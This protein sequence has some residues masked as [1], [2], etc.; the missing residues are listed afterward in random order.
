MQILKE[1]Y[2]ITK[3]KMCAA[4]FDMEKKQQNDRLTAEMTSLFKIMDKIIVTCLSA[5]IDTVPS[6]ELYGYN[7]FK[8]LFLE[9]L[10]MGH[11]HKD[12]F[13][14]MYMKHRESI[15]SGAKRD[16]WIVSN[17]VFLRSGDG[18]RGADKSIYIKLSYFYAVAMNKK[19]DIMQNTTS[20]QYDPAINN[21]DGMLLHIY[22]YIREIVPDT[23]RSKLNGYITDLERD[24]GILKIETPSD[25]AAGL[26][27]NPL[28]VPSGMGNPPGVPGGTGNPPG[29]PGGFPIDFGSIFRSINIQEV[30]TALHTPPQKPGDNPIMNMVTTVARQ[31]EESKVLN[32]LSGGGP[33]PG[34]LTK[35]IQSIAP[36]VQ[37]AVQ[38]ITTDLK[39]GDQVRAFTSSSIP[40]GVASTFGATTAAAISAGKAETAD[41]KLSATSNDS[42]IVGAASAAPTISGPAL[43]AP[44]ISGAG[45]VIPATL[46]ASPTVSMIPQAAAVITFVASTQSPPSIAADILLS[47]M[48]ASGMSASGNKPTSSVKIEEQ[49]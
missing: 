2:I 34:E 29:V 18:I 41:G 27:G 1:H 7:K 38:K 14:A 28:G 8:K 4:R 43:A 15:L 22:R 48:S 19:R 40:S 6:P 16:S 49:L 47:G 10:K 39:L 12:D 45:A 9:E 24:L 30:I 46:P 26:F 17:D 32:N 23:D 37:D 21:P 11:E 35:A 31:L 25:S 13:L 36:G 44:T 20:K 3:A 33:K 42:K 5:E